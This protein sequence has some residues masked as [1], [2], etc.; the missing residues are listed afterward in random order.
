M[1]EVDYSTWYVIGARMET[2]WFDEYERFVFD[3][4]EWD[5]V[6]H[7]MF[8]PHPTAAVMSLAV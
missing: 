4:G 1:R 8:F 6:M 5:D 3:S 7:S 2:T